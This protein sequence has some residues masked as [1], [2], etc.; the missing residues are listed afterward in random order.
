MTRGRPTDPRVLRRIRVD[1]RNGF[2]QAET[3]RRNDCSISV[4]K[5]VKNDL[6]YDG[7]AAFRGALEDAGP[8]GPIP[9]DQLCAEA[10]AALD[11]IELFAMRYFGLVLMP[12]QRMAT[13]KIVE[14]QGSPRE[15]YVV[16][17]VA[18]GSGK[19]TFFTLVLP[20]W[21]TCRDRSI[22]GFI[23]SASTT[24]AEWYTGRLRTA[25][26][27]RVPV[28][29]KPKDLE[30][31]IA[32]D[33]V[34]TLVEDFGR[35]KPEAGED[36]WQAGA[37][38]VAQFED[39]PLS[40]KERT[41]SAFGRASTFLGT[42]VDL[43]IWDDAYDPSQVRTAQAREDMFEWWSDI[44]ETRLEPGGLLLLQ[45]QRLGAD[46][47]YR[48]ALD[49]KAAVFD[50]EGE[51]L[52]ESAGA[53]KYHHIVFKAHYDEKCRGPETHRMDSA[54]YPD[55]CLLYPRRLPWRKLRTVQTNMPDKFE[56]V[57]QQQDVS[58]QHVLVN[59]LWISGGVDAAGVEYPGCWDKDRDLCE[60]P[61][62]LSAPIL[63]IAT[64]DPS[65]TKYWAI[66]WW[67]VHPDS[68]QRFLLDLVR[69][70]MGADAF[71]DWIAELNEF[72][73][74]A[75]E[76]QR[77]SVDLGLPIT[78]WVVE[79][80]AAQRFLLAMDHVRRWRAKWSVEIVPHSTTQR[81]LDPEYGV[82]SIGPRFRYG[83]IRLPGKNGTTARTTSLKLIDEVTRYP[84]ARTDDQ[85]HACWFMEFHQANLRPGLAQI[86]T[87]HRPSWM[88]HRRF[89]GV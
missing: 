50:E 35:F 11:D 24:N 69:E 53:R 30:L 56:T 75:E 39:V 20:A 9:R 62:G 66:Q 25:F 55:G 47:L 86:P 7:G 41:W 31:G 4:V 65:P 72:S 33:A 54:P 71:L 13:E 59:P 70:P 3:A 84:E 77:R 5:A 45:G 26:T 85:V 58:A 43:C 10:S 63:S 46:D 48:Y 74:V 15:E 89:A 83:Q 87:E 67:A 21:A 27:R 82:Q 73:G 76:W 8:V 2:T 16:L 79:I 34:A 60:L 40:E 6:P 19:S 88:H 22:R 61:K 12:W 52:D 49:Q 17:N 32:V 80:N 23:G 68:E 64:V 18:P 78:H 1:L 81:K 51:E 28:K 14:L 36:V 38:S 37:F 44:A 42:R 57:Y 29:A